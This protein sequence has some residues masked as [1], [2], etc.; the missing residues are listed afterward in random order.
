MRMKPTPERQELTALLKRAAQ[1]AA[2]M[3]PAERAAMIEAQRES[4]VRAEMSWPRPCRQ[5]IDGVMV[6]ASYEDYCN[7]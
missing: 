1:Q 4:Y 3:T 7:G 5:M 6:Y 2:E